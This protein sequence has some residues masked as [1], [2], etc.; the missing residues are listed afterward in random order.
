MRKV[1]LFTL[2][3]CLAM[4][5]AVASAHTCGG[6]KHEHTGSVYSTCDKHGAGC[7]VAGKSG[8]CKQRGRSCG[9]E[10]G[11]K[12]STEELDERALRLECVY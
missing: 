10:T 12:L 11:K 9:C 8:T 2:T 6:C 1:T 7:K 5:P 3:L 4:V